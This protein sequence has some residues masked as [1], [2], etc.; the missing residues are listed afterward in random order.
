MNHGRDIKCRVV[1]APGPTE[2]LS[3]SVLLRGFRVPQS[4]FYPQRETTQRGNRRGY[5]EWH[6]V[7]FCQNRTLVPILFAVVRSRRCVGAHDDTI[8][9]PPFTHV[10]H[11]SVITVTGCCLWRV[12]GSHL[13]PCRNGRVSSAIRRLVYRRRARP[14]TPRAVP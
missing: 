10:S 13:K 11:P 3:A 7:L 6:V 5:I 8:Y 2:L 4:G 12:P 9:F 1:N 14:D